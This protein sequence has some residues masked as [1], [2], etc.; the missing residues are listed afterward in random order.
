MQTILSEDKEGHFCPE[1]M[2]LGENKN[3]KISSTSPALFSL[4]DSV[5][6]EACRSIVS[7]TDL[8][9]K[10]ILEGR[11]SVGNKKELE[12]RLYHIFY[13]HLLEANT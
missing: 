3:T 2:L 13:R 1:W 12:R 9:A 10:T 4:I 11:I 7:L 5:S 8:K 6:K